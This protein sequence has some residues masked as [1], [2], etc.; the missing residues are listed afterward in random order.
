MLILFFYNVANLFFGLLFRTARFW[1]R[2]T[3]RSKHYFLNI[4]RLKRGKKRGCRASWYKK[5]RALFLD[6]LLFK[7]TKFFWRRS[8]RKE[9]KPKNKR[10]FRA[11]RRRRFKAE[12][13]R[14]KQIYRLLR[15]SRPL[16]KLCI[17]RKKLAVSVARRKKARSLKCNRLAVSAVH[18]QKAQSLKKDQ[19]FSSKLILKERRL[20]GLLRVGERF[21][22]KINLPFSSGQLFTRFKTPKTSSDSRF[23]NKV[24]YYRA[25]PSSSKTSRV[26]FR[27]RPMHFLRL[28]LYF[29]LLF[30]KRASNSWNSLIRPQI[31]PFCVFSSFYFFPS[32]FFF[33]AEIALFGTP[34]LF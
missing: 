14:R 34:A 29:P 4:F 17:P 19:N 15:K 12:K 22:P 32:P 24:G 33:A 2:R 13:N 1:K 20:A 25:A 26:F 6:R 27:K 3:K 28:P 11:I 5:R 21:F 31:F 7:F 10:I 8:F 16:L 9:V 18:P 30:L 23:S